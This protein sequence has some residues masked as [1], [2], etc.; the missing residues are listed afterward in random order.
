MTRQRRH[1]E[2][3]RQA[4]SN[5]DGARAEHLA[6]R[7]LEAHGLELLQRNYCCRLGEIDLGMGLRSRRRGGVD[8]DVV[9]VQPVQ[10][11]LG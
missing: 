6:L 8:G 5:V 10:G 4:A 3:R 11:F 7:H 1:A 2:P 9:L